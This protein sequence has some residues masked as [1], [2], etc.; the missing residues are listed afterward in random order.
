[1]S[2]V[3]FSPLSM[4]F[5]AYGFVVILVGLM[6]EQKRNF[7]FVNYIFN[8]IGYQSSW[9]SVFAVHI[10][11][12]GSGAQWWYCLSIYKNRKEENLY[13]SLCVYVCMYECVR[14]FFCTQGRLLIIR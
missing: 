1:M 13:I 6:G 3:I 7:D 4:L 5:L 8:F 11:I 10:L 12:I 2:D 9:S 14:V